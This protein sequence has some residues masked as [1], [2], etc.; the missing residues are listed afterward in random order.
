MVKVSF[1]F[2]FSF[3][4]S[5]RLFEAGNYHQLVALSLSSP[6]LVWKSVRTWAGVQRNRRALQPPSGIA[7]MLNHIRRSLEEPFLTV[8]P[9]YPGNRCYLCNKM[10]Y[11]FFLANSLLPLQSQ[12]QAELNH[13]ALRRLSQAKHL[14][15]CSPIPLSSL[16]LVAS[17]VAA[18]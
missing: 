8:R 18:A 6:L 7:V 12:L 17:A 1:F 13:P 14:E 11:M 15:S 5:Y 2:F 3:A 9:C 4:L 16:S 10:L